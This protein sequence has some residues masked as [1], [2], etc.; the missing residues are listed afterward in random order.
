MLTKEIEVIPKKLG[1]GSQTLR[2]LQKIMKLLIL[3]V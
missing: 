3:E 1:Q 2:K